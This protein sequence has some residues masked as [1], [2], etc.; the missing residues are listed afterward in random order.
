MC[1]SFFPSRAELEKKARS[2]Y[3]V[4]FHSIQTWTQMDKSRLARLRRLL[5]SWKRTG[6]RIVL[7]APPFHPLTYERLYSLSTVRARFLEMD[8]S[9]SQ[10]AKTDGF[11]Y[12]NARNPGNFCPESHFL[13]S[14]HSDPTCAR[15]IA[16]R[17]LASLN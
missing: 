5:S 9:L 17:V 11:E 13:D 4:N 8:D 3:D 16:T 10:L 12:F 2:Y 15:A 6:A 7:I 1:P 14:H